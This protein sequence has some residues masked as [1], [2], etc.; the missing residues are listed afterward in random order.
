MD[1]HSPSGS[2]FKANQRSQV[3]PQRVAPMSLQTARGSVAAAT[4]PA[5]LGEA[6]AT[7][8]A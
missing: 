4:L 5:V 3:T 6:A 1:C 7:L 2:E 8:N